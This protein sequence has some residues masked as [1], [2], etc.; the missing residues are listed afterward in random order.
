MRRM[1][2]LPWRY[3]LLAIPA[4]G[5]AIGIQY[6]VRRIYP[7]SFRSDVAMV[8]KPSSFRADSGNGTL[9]SRA[10]ASKAKVS[11]V[12][13]EMAEL[14]DDENEDANFNALEAKNENDPNGVVDAGEVSQAE[15]DQARYKPSVVQLNTRRDIASETAG[16]ME[17]G[18]KSS[19]STMGE[20]AKLANETA[21]ATITTGAT[22]SNQC[23]SIE[24]RGDGPTFT[25]VD[26]KEWEKVMT[27]YHGVKGEL[28]AW[29]NKHRKEFPDKTA[30]VMEA[31]IQKLKIQRPPANEEPDLTWRGIGIWTQDATG[32]PIIRMGSGLVKLMVKQPQRGRFEM[33]RLVAQTWSPCELQ[34][35]D[36]AGAWDPFVKCLGV[37]DR[38]GCSAGT[39]S[40]AGWAVSTAMAAIVSAPGCT[41]PAFA[42]PTIAGCLKKPKLPLS[43]AESDFNSSTVSKLEARR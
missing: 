5:A 12:D 39:Y 31:Q 32:A 18:V 9:V 1:R 29:L 22:A 24:Y 43:I 35:V 13:A 17:S 40:E 33:A 28:L 23:T 2:D 27:Q 38:K 14:I 30:N 26:D 19:P 4:V 21:S 36:A 41:V 42:D 20:V 6:S 37:E 3:Y 16:A 15:E 10:I 11:E 25:K 34:R 7:E 8:L